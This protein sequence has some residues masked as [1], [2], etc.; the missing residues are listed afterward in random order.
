MA[1]ALPDKGAKIQ[2]Q[3]QALEQALQNTHISDP[4]K[5]TSTEH[6]P[7][8]ASSQAQPMRTITIQVRFELKCK[9]NGIN[10]LCWLV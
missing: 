8:A 3:L 7:I 10:L 2:A 9:L 6:R 5:Q 1:G 4:V